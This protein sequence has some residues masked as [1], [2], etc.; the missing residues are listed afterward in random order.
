MNPTIDSML[1]L[2]RQAP[3]AVLF[4]NQQGEVMM[5]N[6]AAAK[7]FACPSEDFPKH[8]VED[9]IPPDLRAAHRQHHDSFFGEGGRKVMG[10]HAGVAARRL[11]GELIRIEASVSI[12]ETDDGPIAVVIAREVH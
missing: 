5:G 6:D 1:E 12:A 2:I 7:I 9:F 11:N 4:F 3:D 8:R 10:D